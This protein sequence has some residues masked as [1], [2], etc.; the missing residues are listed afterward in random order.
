[1]IAADPAGLVLA[2]GAGRRLGLGP[3]A[4]LEVD[5]RPLIRS[6]AEALL[7]GGCTDVTVV[8]GAYADEVVDIVTGHSHIHVAH[9]PDWAAGMGAS[10][11]CGL[12]TIGPDRT[13][14]VMPVDHPG[15]SA[16]EVQRVIAAHRPGGITAAA[17]RDPL[18]RARRGH[19]VLFD[20]EWTAA[21]A[22]AAYDDVGARELL[23]AHSDIVTSV[24]CSDLSDGGDIDVPADLTR[25]TGDGSRLSSVG[26]DSDAAPRCRG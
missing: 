8:T 14:V 19:P 21:A 12:R 15:I 7:S 4:L 1:M 6:V 9:N 24:D 3:K 23:A 16:A 22:T 10:L 11:R 26:A 5:G 25:L 18:G 2:A 13:I 17:H 20:A